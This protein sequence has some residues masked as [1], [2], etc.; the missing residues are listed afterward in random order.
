MRQSDTGRRMRR[1]AWHQMPAPR[2]PAVGANDRTLKGMTDHPRFEPIRGASDAAHLAYNGGRL[3][4]AV[5]R[6]IDWWLA[7]RESAPPS[8][9][10]HEG[11][12]TR[13]RRGE[14]WAAGE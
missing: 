1:L 14:A 8:A 7:A 2:R 5:L 3:V 6:L 11:D 13:S 4:G 10:G 12:G 9:R